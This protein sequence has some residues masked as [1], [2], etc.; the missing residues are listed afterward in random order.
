MSDFCHL[1][2]YLWH[3]SLLFHVSE[4]LCCCWVSTRSYGDSS[5][6]SSL[7]SIWAIFRFWLKLLWT[8]WYKASSCGCILVHMLFVDMCSPRYVPRSRN[9]RLCSS[10]VLKLGHSFQGTQEPGAPYCAGL[11]S[12]TLAIALQG[13]TPPCSLSR[14]KSLYLSRLSLS[15]DYFADTL[16]MSVWRVLSWLDTAFFTNAFPNPEDAAMF[17]SY[18]DWF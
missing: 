7:M 8:V 18:I 5:V 12:S 17:I 14:G 2:Q 10:C 13:A 9:P 6:Q 3:S 4:I 15:L 16:L 11:D 1:A